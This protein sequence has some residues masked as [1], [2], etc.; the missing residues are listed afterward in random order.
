MGRVEGKVAFITGGARGQGRLHALR[1][2]EEGADVIGVDVCA[3]LESVPYELAGR[4]DLDE[5]G[6]E[7]GGTGRRMFAREADVRDLGALRAAV[8]DG[9]AEL[10]RLDVVIANAGIFSVGGTIADMEEQTWQEMIDVNLTG[11]FHTL[12]VCVPHLNDGGSVI[13]TSS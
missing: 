9:V 2:A 1:L 10:G 3:Q 8:E 6:R 11:V 7:G 12:K 4:E 13:I 5:T